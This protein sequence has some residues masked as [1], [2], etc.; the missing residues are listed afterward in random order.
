MSCITPVSPFSPGIKSVQGNRLTAATRAANFGDRLKNDYIMFGM[1][2][3]GTISFLNREFFISIV[4]KISNGKISDS[5]EA[6]KLP[7]Q[8]GIFY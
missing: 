4:T 3:N 2:C 7:A 8:I 6:L 5:S 1:P